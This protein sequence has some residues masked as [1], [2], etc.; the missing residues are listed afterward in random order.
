LFRLKHRLLFSL[1]C[2]VIAVNAFA[3]D[4]GTTMSFTRE[5]RLR[6]FAPTVSGQLG[7]FTTQSADTLRQGTWSFGVYYNDYDM[8]AGEAREFSPLSARDY[9]DLSY[10]LYRL[11]ASVG[12]GITDRWEVTAMLP[13]DR[14]VANGGDRAGFINGH[15]YHGRFT[16]SGLGNLRLGT[17]FGFGPA[18]GPSN[19]ALLAFADLPTGDDDGGIASGGTDFGIGGAWTGG[20]ASINA[21]YVMR[22]DRDAHDEINDIDVEI[23]NEFQ[24]NAGLNTPIGLFGGTTNWIN[25]I[26][27]ILYTGGDRAPD[28]PV[29]L[30]S[31]L[32][33]WFGTSGWA[34]NAGLRW[35]AA[36]FFEGNDECRF[37]ELD[38]C[39]LSGLIG[40]TFAPMAFARRRLRSRLRFRRPRLRSRRRASR[41]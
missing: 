7:L 34:L 20:M 9:E 28:T 30:V 17:K 40:L 23:P 3:Q 11:S 35:N 18:D 19:F 39:A 33:H 26:N 24:I 16:D 13:W 14:I 6:W 25:E 27:A 10:D 32:R 38:D 4:A 5:D 15:L 31:G 41:R 29:F 12:V 22:G 1:L 36:K 8:L 2:L 21:N 37:T